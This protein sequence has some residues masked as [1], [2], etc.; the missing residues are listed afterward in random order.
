MLVCEYPELTGEALSDGLHVRRAGHG[1]TEPATSPHR[2][3]V[4]FVV[5]EP[6]I[7]VAL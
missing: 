5:G 3:P 6:A 4:K 2:Q 7:D 1:Q